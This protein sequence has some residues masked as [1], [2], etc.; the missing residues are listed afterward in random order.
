MTKS[1]LK[2]KVKAAGSHY[3]D[4]D[5]MR[6]F[7]SKLISVY[8]GPNGVYFVT[9]ER[10]PH[11]PGAYSVRRFSGTNVSTVGTF[12]GHNKPSAQAEAKQLAG[13]AVHAKRKKSTRGTAKRQKPRGR[14]RTASRTKKQRR[15]VRLR[16]IRSGD[17]TWGT[18]TRASE[19]RFGVLD[20][21]HHKAPAGNPKQLKPKQRIVL[22][23]GNSATVVYDDGGPNVLVEV[24]GN[25][26]NQSISR[27]AIRSVR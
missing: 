23:S 14:S 10:G 2:S 19:Y 5:T 12:M 15:L 11:G 3:F 27:Q 20:P 21:F 18:V 16:K 7:N 17:R 6:F 9:Y 25:P 26:W 13:R 4:R 1:D 24:D 22:V 8:E